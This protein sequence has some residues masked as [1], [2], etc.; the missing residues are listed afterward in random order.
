MPNEKFTVD[1]HLFRELGELLV[2]RNSTALV[3]LIKN[4][5]DADATHVVIDGRFLDDPKRGVITIIDDGIGMSPGQFREGFLRIASRLKDSG[6]RKSARFQRRYTGA[7]GIGRLAAHK[8]PRSSSRLSRVP[9]PKYVS[10]SDEL[11][12]ATIDWEKIENLLILDMVEE[13]GAI[14]LETEARRRK[15]EAG[16]TITLRRLRKKWTPADL[17]QLQSEVES[18]RPPS[19]LVD[20]PKGLVK[21]DLLFQKARVAEISGSDPGERV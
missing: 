10:K 14:V 2:G 1:T 16:T 13:S 11:L 20:V 8:L 5:Y 3:E 7:K 9:N 18:F 4:A 17:V 12:R 15:T 6:K 19:V 21:G